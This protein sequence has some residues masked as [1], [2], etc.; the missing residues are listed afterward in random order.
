MLTYSHLD[1]EWP[2]FSWDSSRIEKL[3]GDV[4]FRR[5]ALLASLQGLGFA[6]QQDT[7]LEVLTSDITCSSAIEG[8]HLNELQVKSSV[9]RRLGIEF[10]G[11]P[12]P[13]R[14]IDGVVTMMLDATQQYDRPLTSERLF[15]WHSLLFPTGFSGGHR[16]T[17]GDWRTDSLGPMQVV[18]GPMGQ[19]RVHFEAP[20]AT[21][22]PAECA[23][24]IKWFETNTLDPILS[25]GIA[26]LY[27]VTLHPFDDGNGR[28]ARALADMA[29]ARAD[30]STQ[31]TYSMSAQIH[32][33]RSSYYDVLEQSQRSLEIT[34]WLSWFLE[35]LQGALAE[36]EKVCGVVLHK[37]EFWSRHET[38]AFTDRQR[39]MLNALLDG[40]EGKL[41]TRK[42]AQIQKCSPDTALRELADLVTKGVLVREEAGGRS[43]SYRL[44]E[45]LK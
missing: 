26:H 30:K 39:R 18:S 34:D 13:D 31:R 2:R 44:A 24:F 9:A 28:I 27:F 32:L 37:Q 12:Q 38:L 22:L 14:H 40:F 41:Q 16:I 42:Y 6:I 45:M 23:A 43:T 8:E 5:G 36:A 7:I 1:P 21:R 10:A 4:H 17:V 19:E 25:A 20:A 35:R 15:G 11:V 29:L 33:H 3:L